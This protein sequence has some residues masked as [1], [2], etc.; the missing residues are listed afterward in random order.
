MLGTVA[1]SRH[2]LPHL[3]A[4]ARSQ[5]SGPKPVLA[6]F[7]SLG[8]WQG[9]A[10]FGVYASTKF[11]VTGLTESLHAELEPLGVAAVVVEPGYFRTEFLHTSTAGG[12]ERR[13]KAET[14]IPAYDDTAVGAVRR[15]LDQ[16]NDAQLGD[17][18][19]GATVIVDVL[20][21]SGVAEGREI[22][23]RLVLGSDI[24]KAIR[25]K[26]AR[27]LGLVK[28]WESIAASTDHT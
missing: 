4:A 17:P 18:V 10:A 11:A 14:V 3:R 16:A 6:T 13:I 24:V 22:P 5:P 15:A 1:V 2:A 23:M 28:E 7:G 12:P 8:S 19:K 26:C 20:T 21:R 25:D 27:S 9:D